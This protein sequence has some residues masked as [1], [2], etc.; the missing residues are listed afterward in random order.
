MTIAGSYDC[1]TKTPM[2]PQKGVLTIVPGEGGAFSGDITGDL[3]S[4]EIK[5]GTI[6]GNTLT[7]QMKM[8][9][10]MPIELDCTATIEGDALT[11]KVKAGM[12]G[13]MDLAGT[14]KM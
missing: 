1:V 14:R 8:T 5:G 3:G 6:T 11:G 13:T 10:P 7:W 4:M 9:M 2:G 12:F